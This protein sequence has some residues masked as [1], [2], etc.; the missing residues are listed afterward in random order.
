M[1]AGLDIKKARNIALRLLTYRARS[2]KEIADHLDNKGFSEQVTAMVL[3]ELEGYGYL[4]D[5]KFTLNF[6]SHSKSRGFGLLRIRYELLL[7]GI[8]KK[9]VDSK[10]DECFEPGDDLNRIKALLKKREIKDQQICDKWIRR[11]LSYLKNRGFQDSLI[12]KALMEY[13][14]ND[15][16]FLD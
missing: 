3:K 6:I 15:Y 13:P 1:D 7:K 8:D 12:R 11:Q 10:I 9:T 4:D 2:R 14:I 5:E 16:N